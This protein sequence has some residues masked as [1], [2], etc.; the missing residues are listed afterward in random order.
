[1]SYFKK[2]LLA[3]TIFYLC[4]EQLHTFPFRYV[5]LTL[6]CIGNSKFLLASP[7]QSEKN[8]LQEMRVSESPKYIF[9]KSL[10]TKKRMYTLMFLVNKK[11]E[12]FFH[13]TGKLVWKSETQGR[14]SRLIIWSQQL[15]LSNEMQKRIFMR[16]GHYCRRH[17]T[18]T[19]PQ[20]LPPT[21]KKNQ[22]ANT[23]HKIQIQHP[24]D[25]SPQPIWKPPNL[26]LVCF[27][28]ASTPSLMWFLR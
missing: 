15:F 4:L 21:W 3:E 12:N 26:L 7:S 22:N 1:M 18:F 24:T 20:W 28:L 14:I 13:T 25:C 9:R 17:E 23:K 27:V 11:R 6:I 16:L 19:A 5:C 8:E 2:Q 10:K